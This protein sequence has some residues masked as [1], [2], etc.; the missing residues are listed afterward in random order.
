MLQLNGAGVED[1][2]VVASGMQS[3]SSCTSKG[4]IFGYMP[5]DVW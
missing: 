5:V 4:R 1:A 3:S 2:T